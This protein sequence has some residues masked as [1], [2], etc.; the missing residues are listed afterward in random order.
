MIQRQ[1]R[2]NV[3]F[4]RTRTKLTVVA[5]RLVPRFYLNLCM[6]GKFA[7]DPEGLDL[8]SV[9]A[10]RQEAIKGARSILA[11]DIRCGKLDLNQCIEVADET[12]AVVTSVRFA[13]TVEIVR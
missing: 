8:P 3:R 11:D 5:S 6:G 12:G 1:V 4:R 10:A 2:Q 7:E 9:D 13:E